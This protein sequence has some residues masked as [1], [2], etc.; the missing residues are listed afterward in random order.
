MGEMRHR[1]VVP[2]PTCSVDVRCATE[3][4]INAHKRLVN[5][6]S[7]AKKRMREIELFDA[8]AAAGR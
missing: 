4:D 5:Q 3:G 8:G 7:R 6:K 2:C 1:P